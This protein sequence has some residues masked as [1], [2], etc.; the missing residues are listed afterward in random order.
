M[1]LVEIHGSI[2]KHQ[3]LVCKQNG[4]I[5]IFILLTSEATVSGAMQTRNGFLSVTDQDW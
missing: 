5:I 1:A 4:N 3:P 2:R